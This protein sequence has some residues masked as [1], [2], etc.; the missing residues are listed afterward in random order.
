MSLDGFIARP[1]EA[2]DWVF[3]D[4]SEEVDDL[5][6]GTIAATGA[7]LT[8]RRA[9]DLGRR[10]DRRETTQP[11]GGAWSGPEF[12]I[13]HDPPG[14]EARSSITFLSGPIREAI[15]TASA[16]AEGRN[17]L[18]LGA[19]VVR[20]CLDEDLLDEVHLPVA[21]VLVGDGVRM[22]EPGVR[23]RRFRTVAAAPAG[24]VGLARLPAPALNDAARAGWVRR[25]RS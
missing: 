21:P 24:Q 18:V 1:D 3:E 9:C 22:F 4:P 2:M 17:L 6:A 5:V 7:I 11:F 12:V 16:A 8:D 23:P 14:D 25:G 20:P 10:A 13:T 15:E 19:N